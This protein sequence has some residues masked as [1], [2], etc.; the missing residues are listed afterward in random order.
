MTRGTSGRIVIEIDPELKRLLYA[1]L[2]AQSLTLK[3]WFTQAA[4]NFI[5][6]HQQPRL[7][8]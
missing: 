5:A 3:A 4:K 8:P 6:D 2:A 1:A 7:I